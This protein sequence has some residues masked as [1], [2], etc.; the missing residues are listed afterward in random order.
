MPNTAAVC[1][2]P[3]TQAENL[4]HCQSPLF[5]SMLQPMPFSSRG[6]A[7]WACQGMVID[8]SQTTLDQDFQMDGPVLTRLLP[9]LVSSGPDAAVSLLDSAYPP[10]ANMNSAQAD[11]WLEKLLDKLADSTVGGGNILGNISNVTESALRAAWRRQ[12][13]NGFQSLVS[14][15][16]SSSIRLSEHI[17]V[18]AVKI[19]K[20]GELRQ[21]AKLIVR[22]RGLP[23]KVVQQLA[24][25]FA[26]KAGGQFGVLRVGARDLVRMDRVAVSVANARVNSNSVLRVAGKGGGAI[27]AFGPS[28]ALDFYGAYTSQSG[29]NAV[30]KDFA[31]RSAKSQSGNVLATAAGFAAV[32]AIGAVGAP[33]ILIGLGVGIAVQTVWGYVGGDE[34]AGGAVKGWLD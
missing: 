2:A 5:S 31:I 21:G 14:G 25:E 34:A 7:G 17:T 32:A 27:L 22:V 20:G 24:P 30:S 9:D 11:Q 13:A 19:G 29:A 28:A 26:P 15:A 3:T 8:V 1:R 16:S 4:A 10:P 18:Q 33:A 23:T 12:A 6:P